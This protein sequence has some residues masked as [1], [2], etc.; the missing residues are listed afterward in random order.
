M[1]AAGV[2]AAAASA[3]RRRGVLPPDS[4]P[5]AQSRRGG[6]APGAG[7]QFVRAVVRQ[8]ETTADTAAS[9]PSLGV[10]L[11]ERLLR[12]EGDPL[13]QNRRV[14]KHRHNDR[15]GPVMKG[16]GI[17][18][19]QHIAD[20]YA[21]VFLYWTELTVGEALPGDDLRAVAGGTGTQQR[22]VGT[23]AAYGYCY[24]VAEGRGLGGH[25]RGRCS[26]DD[27]EGKRERGKREREEP[28][29]SRTLQT[30][31]RRKRNTDA[32]RRGQGRT[33]NKPERQ[34]RGAGRTDD[35]TRGGCGSAGTFRGREEDDRLASGSFGR[36]EQLSCCLL[37]SRLDRV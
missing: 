13:L 10:A 33:N 29:L 4:D 16:R 3:S 34:T 9:V 25:E 24:A 2:F 6:D 7:P 28:F 36:E 27:D 32:A 22:A 23:G 37:G 35:D 21:T 5:G 17:D 8:G 1:A 12:A 14:P 11:V 19:A 15:E 31:S 18:P 30:P 26:D 20:T